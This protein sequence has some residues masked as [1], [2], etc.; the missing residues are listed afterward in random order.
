[1]DDNR[2]AILNDSNRIISKLQLLS[3]FFGDDIIYKIYLRSQVI[4]QLFED[5]IELDINKLELFHLQFTQTLIELL[6]QIKKNNEK[7]ILILL[8]EIQINKDLID[9]LKSSLLSADQFRNDQQR[10]ALKINTS[11]RKLYQAL[12]DN[13]SD[14]PFSKNINAFS[15]TYAADFFY[16]VEPSLISEM[17]QYNPTEIYSNAYATIHKKLMGL[18][19]KYDFRSSFY[20]GLK[21]G[22]Q[23]LEVYSLNETDRYFIYSPARQLFLFCDVT[24][25]DTANLN[26]ELSKKGQ[27][28][29][30]LTDKNDQ[31]NNSINNIKTT[32]PAEIKTLLV[33]NYRKLNDINFLQSISEV[34]VQAN[35][36]KSMLNTDMI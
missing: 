3:V 8:D 17:T 29:Q 31:L 19:C 26:N 12:S 32:I 36:L 20:C 5:N 9:K 25:I 34:D 13:T 24:Q 2:K 21:A 23:V 1:M 15:N 4:H 11:L 30:E 10:Q 7:S 33:E 14:Y 6:R 35:M 27:F 16:T 18:L 28:I 22:E